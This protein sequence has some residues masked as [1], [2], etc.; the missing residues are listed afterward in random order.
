LVVFF[1]GCDLVLAGVLVILVVLVFFVFLPPLL[2][3]GRIV[4]DLV[5][6]DCSLPV[7]IFRRVLKLSL[8]KA[9]L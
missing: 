5:G 7:S 3:L 1:L 4:L 2:A 8:C 6:Y 9:S